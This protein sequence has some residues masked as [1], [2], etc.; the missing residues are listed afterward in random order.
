[1]EEGGIGR[2]TSGNNNNFNA[3]GMEIEKIDSGTVFGESS[4]LTKLII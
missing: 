1:M 3:L 4:S 2:G